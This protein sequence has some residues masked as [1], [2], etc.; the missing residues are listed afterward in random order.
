MDNRS[1]QHREEKKCAEESDY[2][3][4]WHVFDIKQDVPPVDHSF[5]F[6]VREWGGARG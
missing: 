2:P 3:S 1:Q 4:A 5:V 6:H